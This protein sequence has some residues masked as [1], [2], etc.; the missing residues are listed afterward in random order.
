LAETSSN[1][2]RRKKWYSVKG[3]R[4]FWGRVGRHREVAQTLKTDSPVDFELRREDRDLGNG[5]EEEPTVGFIIT[6][7][8]N[9]G[10]GNRQLSD[11][12]KRENE[13]KNEKIENVMRPSNR[14]SGN[15]VMDNVGRKV[16]TGFQSFRQSQGKKKIGSCEM[17]RKPGEL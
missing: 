16:I 8:F 9:M 1:N 6:V 12:K 14:A 2:S 15:R 3:I 7:G 11:R 5:R 4:L 13:A 17:G 10:G